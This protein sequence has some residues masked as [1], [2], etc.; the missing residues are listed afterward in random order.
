MLCDGR[1][2]KLMVR[3]RKKC[4]ECCAFLCLSQKRG[5]FCIFFNDKYHW[6]MKLLWAQWCA[7][8]AVLKLWPA[9][10]ITNL[11]SVITRSE[12]ESTLLYLLPVCSGFFFSLQREPW[13]GCN[14]SS[15]HGVK[16]HSQCSPS[17]VQDFGKMA[18]VPGVCR[19]KKSWGAQWNQ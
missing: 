8:L 16:M 14:D 9:I 10:Q 12:L 18:S 13:G 7:S 15:T 6:N 19:G 5:N 17:L 1:A 2:R 4:K 3:I 11:M